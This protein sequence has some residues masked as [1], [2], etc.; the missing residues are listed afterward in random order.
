MAPSN[1]INCEN[2]RTLE[3]IL[4]VESYFYFIGQVVGK[5]NNEMNFIILINRYIAVGFEL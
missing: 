4:T 1:G 3:N 2:A 5:E